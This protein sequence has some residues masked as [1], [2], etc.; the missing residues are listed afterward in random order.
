MQLELQNISKKINNNTINDDVNLK[1][2]KGELIGLIGA[3]GAG[4]STLLKLITTTISPTQGDIFLN[5][6]SVLKNPKL[7]RKELGYLPQN[8]PIYDNLTIIEFLLFMATL[9]DI[10][11]KIAKEQI[12]IY[13]NQFNL[14]NSLNVKLSELSGGM[15][16]KV[17][18]ITALLGNPK[19]I[20][21][22]EPANGLD[23][24]ERNNLR[25]L[26][27]SL[28]KEKIIIY[29]THIITDVEQVANRIIVLESGQVTFDGNDANLIETVNSNVWTFDIK[30]ENDISNE[31]IIISRKSNGDKINLR[32]VSNNK[33]SDNAINVKATLEDAYLSHI[34]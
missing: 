1:F 15:L 9:K 17:G 11:T 20:V 16:Q 3:N 22:D 31:Y 25:N 14:S 2:S 32:V 10:D 27:V 8:F 18:I 34:K 24:T 12:D 28:S 26:L 23:P 6:I 21:L 29:S 13:T 33:P 5:Q 30:N 4:K 7:L 19:V